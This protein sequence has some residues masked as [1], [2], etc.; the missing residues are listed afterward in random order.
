[1]I[2]LVNL[3][4]DEQHDEAMQSVRRCKNTTSSCVKQL[5][6]KT[7]TNS[8]EAP[9]QEVSELVEAGSLDM[10]T[11]ILFSILSSLCKTKELE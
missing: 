3:G 6:T 2:V 1:M 4:A 5:M 11:R 10:D 7:T 9:P 8:R